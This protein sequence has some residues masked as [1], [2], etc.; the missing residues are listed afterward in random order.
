MSMTRQELY[1]RIRTTSKEAYILEEMKR[2]GFWGDSEKPTLAEELINK[3]ARLQKELS[4]LNQKQRQYNSREAMLK[5]VRLERMKASKEKQKETKAR[6]EEKVRL[7]AEKWA[8]TQKTNIIY[9]GQEVSEGLNNTTSDKEKL[10]K[11]KLPYFENIVEFSEK[12]NKPISELRFLAFQRSVSKVNQYHN[13]YVPKKSG[14]KRLISAPKPKLKHTQNWIKTNVLDKIEINENVHGFVKERSILT[15]AE[16]HQN[17]NLVISLD[18]KDFFPSISYKRVKG[19]FL[20]FGYSEQLSTLFGLLTTHN[21]TDKLN[22]DG[23]IYYAQK[24]DKETGKTNRFLPQG[25]PASPAITTLIAYKMDKRLEGLAKKMGFTYTRYAD[26]LT[27]S[28]DLDLKKDTKAT[29]K[30]IGSLLYFVKKVVTS[31]GFEIHPDKTH[32]MRKGNQQKVTGIIVNQNT[33]NKLGIDRQTLRKFRAFLH[34]TAKTGWKVDKNAK[35][36]KWGI[37]PDPKQAALGF[38]SFI[39]M[40]DAEKGEKFIQKIKSIPTA[41]DYLQTDDTTLVSQKT[42]EKT[43][44][45][46][47][48]KSKESEQEI[49]KQS[50]E[51]DWWDIF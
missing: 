8:E 2:L 4:E 40:V 42:E 39:K 20:K 9:L 16:P 17:K 19:L 5:E 13:Y 6:N 10:E 28:S 29:N 30:I 11:L 43:L 49:E 26:D 1:D 7:K 14:G 37:H 45:Q 33:E 23:E 47:E 51:S 41:E 31:E 36:K 34:Q 12:I 25:S 18:L 46:V 38:A 32:I 48:T 24:V 21:E 44:K 22:V 27:F 50:D 3:Q 15:N 35:D